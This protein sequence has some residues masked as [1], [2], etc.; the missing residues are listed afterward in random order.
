MGHRW[1]KWLGTGLL[2]ALAASTAWAQS[3]TTG[4]L[5][6]KVTDDSGAP[7]PGVSVEIRGSTLI[8]GARTLVTDKAGRF[9][10][11]EVPPGSYDVTVTLQGFQTVKRAGLD[12]TLGN[13][14][15]VPVT[16][17]T[18]TVSET[19]EVIGEA[20][21]IDVTS[22]G[23]STNISNEILQNLPTARFQPAA[24]NLAP[25]INLNSAYGGGDG[26]GNSYQIDGVDVSDPQSGTPWAFVNYN[27][28]KEVQLV[29]LGAPAEY[30]GF[31]GVV[32]NSVTHS[33]GNKLK[34]LGETLF[35]NKSL[36]SN[37]VDKND[38]NLANFT[39][40]TIKKATD[41]TL[42]LGGPIAK[43]KLWFFLS[44]QYLTLNS[45]NG[46]PDRTEKDPRVFGKLTWQA[47]QSSNVDAWLEWDKYDITGR[48]GNA[49]TPLEATVKENAPEFAW[50]VSDRTVLSEN[51]ILTI[52]E[53]GFNGF[54]YLD[55]QNGFNIPGRLNADSGKYSVNSYYFFKAN[56]TRNQLNGSLSHYA[57][58]FIK[59]DHDFK[60][61]M[62]V[63]RSYVQNRYGYT[64]GVWFYDHP[65]TADSPAYTTGYYGHGYNVH[66]LST[67]LST[68]AQDTWRVGPRLTINPGLRLDLDRGNVRN[69]QVYKSNV[70][71]PRLGFAW[72]LAGNGKTLVKAHA[73]R[74]Y[75]AVAAQFYYWVDPNAFEAGE[76][77]NIF[78]D[79]TSEHVA[80]LAGG[81]Y[82]I[83]SN[84]RQPYLDQV[85]FGIDRELV[86]GLTFSGTLVYRENKDFVE[87]VSRDG[88][89]VP[90]TGEVGM[91]DPKTRT[92]VGT[93]QRVTLYDY[94]NPGTDT[95]IVTNPSGL[96]RTYKGAILS[97]TRRFRDNWQFVG[98]YVYSKTRGNFDNHPTNAGGDPGGPGPFLD[99]PNSLV[100]AE[101]R[102]THDQTHQVKLQGTYNI[103]KI[104]L[105][106]SGNYTYYTGDTWTPLT[107]CLLQSDGTCHQ[108]PQGTVR[109][110]AEPRGSRRLPAWNQIDLRAE[111]Q[112]PI[113]QGNAGL[114]LDVFNAT[115]Q[116]IALSVS[117]REGLSSFGRPLTYAT[118]RNYRLGLR[119]VF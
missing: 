45:S 71:A 16:L 111:W 24:L 97:L 108:F 107:T 11:P 91:F 47:T 101:G 15:D 119:Y 73:G 102:L 51:T 82:A 22:A 110:F 49:T 118:P 31:T 21:T 115:N 6:G 86:P 67:R 19:V 63:E 90:V 7:L 104:H 84:V 88:Q 60:F 65:A 4:A 35:T 48:G 34:G 9:R 89:F 66:A 59:G 113:A 62:E 37:N 116:G 52:A 57:S 50:N 3:K 28:I 53:A 95:L 27:I 18:E 43:D 5:T 68:Y 80:D 94:L 39:A 29:G 77:R 106:L 105:S 112:L 44:G 41:S 109:Y 61:G 30:G 8:G 17:R 83:D 96:K 14:V 23:T 75:E 93:G 56:R 32:F 85:I 20:P 69:G 58:N 12:V 54:Y 117:N 42:Q 64:T 38:P 40:P 33:G 92:Y 36:T 79:G 70:I 76:I 13:T 55:P 103:P 25:G 72:D 26:S 74:Y 87:T 114:I 1:Q 10:L 100:N 81:H 99:T 2:L 98:S 78:P 46:G